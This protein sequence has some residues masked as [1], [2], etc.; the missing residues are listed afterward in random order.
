MTQILAINGSYREGGAID[1]A[2]EVAVQAAL[3]AGATIEVI[4]LRDFPIQFC[5]N[6]RQCT[7]QPGEAPGECVQQ[8]GMRDLVDKIETADGL[9]LASPTNFS[10]VTAVFKRFMERL[11]VYAYW[12]WGSHAPTHRRKN[13]SKRAVLIASCAAPGLMG[14]LFFTTLKQLKLTAKTIGAKPVG[15]VFVGLMSQEEA[16]ELPESIKERVRAAAIKLV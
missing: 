6:C 15:T 4:H 12:P 1:Q 5:R 9:I 11:V 8:D 3:A 7:Q 14:R 10:S 16:P 13:T 2:V